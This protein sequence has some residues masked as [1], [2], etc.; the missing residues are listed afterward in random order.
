VNRID[1]Q[2]AI[3]YFHPWEIDAGQ[4][5]IDGINAKTRF[6]HYVNLHRTETRVRRLLTDFSW[7]R[8]D[9]I[10]LPDSPPKVWE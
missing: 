9:E 1:G 4:P 3:F 6:R 5:R 8:M 10:F 7:A 2:S